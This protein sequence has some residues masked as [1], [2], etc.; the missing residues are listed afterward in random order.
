MRL[1]GQSATLARLM[2]RFMLDLLERVTQTLRREGF[3]F[4]LDRGTLLGAFRN[5]RLV[6]ADDDIDLRV[7]Q[8]DGPGIAAAL[9]RD[10]PEHLELVIHHHG[11]TVREPDADH[12]WPWFRN[13]DGEFPVAATPGFVDGVFHHAPTAMTVVPR[14]QSIFRKPN[15]DLY[16][17][18]E[19]AHHCCVP[20]PLDAPWRDDGR[21]YFCLPARRR[22]DMLVPV[23]L[24]R[25]LGVA[26][27]E[28]RDYPAPGRTEEYLTWIFG[29]IGDNAVHNRETG[30]WEPAPES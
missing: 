16:C 13:D 21:E 19:S 10:L 17:C 15:L 24:V 23:D 25:P 2:E 30:Y 1:S 7:L 4:W 3:E 9:R 8:R 6:P 22:H 18:L 20:D 26:R 29:Y 5:G 27:L 11:A 14:G 28:G 12:P